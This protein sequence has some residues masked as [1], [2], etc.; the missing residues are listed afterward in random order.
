MSPSRDQSHF[1]LCST[2]IASGNSFLFH[3]LFSTVDQISR[4]GRVIRGGVQLLG[5][6]WRMS[7]HIT[8]CL[9]RSVGP[10]KCSRSAFSSGIME[11]CCQAACCMIFRDAVCSGAEKT[12]WGRVS[13]R[14]RVQLHAWPDS[15]DEPLYFIMS[16]LVMWPQGPCALMKWTEWIT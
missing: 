15:R 4:R 3:S 8:C 6:S 10:F 5:M 11:R 13:F 2:F 9:R 16:G 1:F 7:S 14:L 12:G